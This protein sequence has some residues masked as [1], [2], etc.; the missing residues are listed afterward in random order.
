MLSIVGQKF[1]ITVLPP[2]GREN[3]SCIKKS[4]NI[5]FKRPILN[6]WIQ[7]PA[8]SLFHNLF[9]SGSADHIITKSENKAKASKQ[10]NELHPE[11]GNTV[12][13]HNIY[14][15]KCTIT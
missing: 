8:Q 4:F 10:R 11:K 1:Q 5:C 3:F 13:Y 6:I 2:V 9:I 15:P 12:S 7:F 14:T